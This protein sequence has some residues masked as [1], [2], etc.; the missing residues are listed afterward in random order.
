MSITARDICLLLYG[1]NI[2]MF[3]IGIAKISAF[4]S[5]NN[6]L[7]SFGLVGLICGISQA[8]CSVVAYWTD[9]DMKILVILFA[10]FWIILVQVTTWLY[11]FRLETIGVNLASF[12][13]WKWIPWLILVAQFPGIILYNLVLYIDS[14]VLGTTIFL[15]TFDVV[16]VF[17][18]IVLYVKLMRNVIFILE[19]RSNLKKRINYEMLICCCVVVVLDLLLIISLC[20]AGP[21]INIIVSS[22]SYLFRILVVIRFYELLLFHMGDNNPDPFG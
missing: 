18:E 14:I 9:M 17:I 7:V 21:H 5:K 19:Y 6:R 13:Y 1:I 3:I 16:L 15:I 22:T 4:S 10:P 20:T 12:K 8:T 11:L 2:S